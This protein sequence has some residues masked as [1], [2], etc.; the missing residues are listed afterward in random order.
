MPQLLVSDTSILID[1]ERGNLLQATFKLPRP[2]AV[3][4]VLYESELRNTNG[5]LLIGLGRG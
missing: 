1:L 2:L 3:P 5:E 4:D